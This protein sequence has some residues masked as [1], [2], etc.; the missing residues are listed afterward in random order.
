M[1]LG[2]VTNDDPEMGQG[3]GGA[4]PDAPTGGGA[5]GGPP[6]PG[7]F[8]AA[9]ARNNMSPGISAPGPGDMAAATTMITQAIGLL[10]AA[11]Q[12]LPL[13]N[14]LHSDVKAIGS[15]SRHLGSS[16]MGGPGA[17]IQATSLKDQMRDLIKNSVLQRIMAM[18][19]SQQG[20]QSEQ[21]P[22]G[23]MPPGGAPM[24]STPLP[25]S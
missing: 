18:Q 15:L 14:K 13:G 20:P 7:G 16:G 19:Q 1:A 4:P 10:Q 11:M 3:P 12:G 2:D 22:A 25:G 8:L 23:P 17:G 5:P 24:P 21:S 9:M 6:A